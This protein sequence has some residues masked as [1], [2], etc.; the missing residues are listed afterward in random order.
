MKRITEVDALRGIAILMMV[1]YH[2]IFDLEFL[3][4]ADIGLFSLPL[5]LF[6][7]AIGS[8]FIMLAGVSVILSESANREGFIHHAKR[9]AFLGVVALA[10]TL[11]TWIYPHDAFI[12]FGII[13]FLALSILIAPFF[14][15]FGRSNAAFGL[16]VIFL[17]FWA[18]GLETDNGLLFW[19][20]LI[21]ADYYALDFYP[22]LPWFGVFLIGMAIGKTVF[23]RG[24]A[25]WK[26]PLIQGKAADALAYAG[27]N[28]LIIYLAHQPI[29]VGLMLIL[30]II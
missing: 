3:G 25:I 5:V 18:S 23:P 24:E 21:R 6:Q 10:I 30:K 1:A 17:G 27:R 7:R 19:L 26:G 16:L 20:G 2:I 22:M 9:A 4:I 14:L 11:A 15:R 8:L 12:T 29:L 13:H 28:S